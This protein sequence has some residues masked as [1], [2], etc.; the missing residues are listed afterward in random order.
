MKISVGFR[1]NLEEMLHVAANSTLIVI[2][3]QP[4]FL[5]PIEGSQTVVERSKFMVR[6][7]AKLG[8]PVLATEQYPERMGGTD[9]ELK[10]ELTDAEA[11]IFGK[12]AFSAMGSPDFVAA[13]E[14][15]GR[16]HAVLVGIETHICVTQTALELKAKGHEVT[17]VADAV[18]ARPGRHESAVQRL[19]N[20]GVDV[21]HSE[22]V[23]YEWMR[24]AEH[25]A[26]REILGLVKA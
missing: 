4:S 21:A 22:S 1:S 16:N 14:S 18:S 19:L 8:I 20:H 10:H 2:D 17:I 25:P 11:L 9:P 7:A 23:V 12:M 26:F 6:V 3:L 5:N 24:S 15:T 13:Y